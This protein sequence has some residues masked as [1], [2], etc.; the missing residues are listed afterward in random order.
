MNVMRLAVVVCV[1]ALTG[2]GT[3]P[4]EPLPGDAGAYQFTNLHGKR[5]Y[6]VSPLPPTGVLDTVVDSVYRRSVDTIK[7]TSGGGI[8]DSTTVIHWAESYRAFRYYLDSAGTIVARDSGAS[9]RRVGV[10]NG[11]VY[12]DPS[13]QDVI[14]SSPLTPGAQWFVRI[15]SSIVGQVAGEEALQ[16]K[17]GRTRSYHV[18]LGGLGDDWWAPELGR[19]Q[20][21]EIG[22][23]G[24]WE[25]GTL[26]GLE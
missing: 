17:I 10:M 8:V 21:E 12:D 1:A 9:F 5:F 19:I 3:E 4:Q 24:L 7:W 18:L 22:K 14:L 11:R 26:I 2:C 6:E 20:Y 23:S 16:L 13:L 25:R 15:D